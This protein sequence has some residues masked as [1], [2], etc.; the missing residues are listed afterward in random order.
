[1][2]NPPLATQTAGTILNRMEEELTHAGS[3][4]SAQWA[5]IKAQGKAVPVRKF[6]HILI[7]GCGDSYYA[8]LA[9]RVAL[10]QLSG[11]PVAVMPSME[12]AC[13][14][15][16][17][18]E[19]NALMFAVSVSGK[20]ERTIEAVVRHRE[21]GGVAVAITAFPDNQLSSSA[22]S[23][24]T[25]GLR[26]TPGPVPGT[27]NYLGSLLALLGVGL[28]MEAREGGTCSAADA[29]VLAVLSMI[30]QAFAD[31]TKKSPSLVRS[32]TPPFFALGSGPDLGAVSFGVAKFLEAAATVGVAQD[33]EEWAHEQYFATGE[34]TTTFICS[35]T[36]ATDERA[37]RVARSVAAVGGLPV[38]IGVENDA[39]GPVNIPLPKTS[40]MLAPLVAWVPL[41]VMALE[42]ARHHESSPFGID[43]PNRMSTVDSDIYV[44]SSNPDGD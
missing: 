42:Y 37:R 43:R 23:V 30:D 44:M 8:G 17:L 41:A 19:S 14:P 33:L 39:S 40:P 29:E 35:T 27:A 9:M 28:E 25:T 11:L 34:G 5:G 15:S 36:P 31:A 21:R 24:V 18:L 2:N 7:T 1:M 10:E 4:A 38:T 20:V 13:F 22:N 32:L 26:G 16:R 3:A 12:A 6:D